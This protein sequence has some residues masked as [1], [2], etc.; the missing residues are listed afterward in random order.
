[1]ALEACTLSSIYLFFILPFFSM[2]IEMYFFL[3]LPRVRE[4]ES[5]FPFFSQSEWKESRSSPPL[6]FRLGIDRLPFLYFQLLRLFF[7]PSMLVLGIG[8]VF[9]D[10]KRIPPSFFPAISW[11]FSLFFPVGVSKGLFFSFFLTSSEAQTFP[12]LGTDGPPLSLFPARDFPPHVLPAT[13]FFVW[14]L[15]PA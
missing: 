5:F 2:R 8:A 11:L 7:F 10:E 4:K 14:R 12:Q 1:M 13:D 9:P 15:C 6:F 3:S